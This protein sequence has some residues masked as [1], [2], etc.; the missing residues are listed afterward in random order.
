M[1]S[2][3]KG[4]RPIPIE[5]GR[6]GRHDVRLRWEDGHD[7]L[8]PARTLRLLCPC[9]GCISEDTGEPLLNPTT[10]PDDVHPLVIEPVGRYA[11][12]IRWSD[13][14]ITGIYSWDY[15]RERCPCCLG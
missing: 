15:L 1:P 11:M 5:V 4:K 8:F 14:H 7:S 13:G 6:S 10:V 2:D 12:Q 9:A 3:D